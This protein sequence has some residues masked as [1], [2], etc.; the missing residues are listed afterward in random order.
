M[1]RKTLQ[2]KILAEITEHLKLQ[3]FCLIKN[4]GIWPKSHEISKFDAGICN[5]E[6]N[7]L[8]CRLNIA[9]SRLH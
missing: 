4:I 2:N 7:F 9:C 5:F 3:R 1:L 8:S 6:H